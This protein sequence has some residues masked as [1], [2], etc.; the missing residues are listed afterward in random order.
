MTANLK[1]L[2]L[3]TAALIVAALIFL[4]P[5]TDWLFG[6]IAWI[7]DNRGI[8]WSVFIV[9]Y[10][11]AT[12]LI[13]PGSILTLGAGFVFGLPVGL[14]LVSVGSVLGA[15]AAF[16]VGRF[17]AREWVERKITDI[18]RFRAIDRAVN[19]D[20]FMI[21]FLIRLSPIFPF[22]LTNY[23]L[24]LTGIR[25]RDYF[26]ASWIGMLPGTVLYVYIGTLAQSVAELASGDLDT[27]MAGRVLLAGGFIATLILT[28]VIT[29]RATRMLNQRLGSEASSGR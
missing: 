24:G 5:V 29:R 6:G 21:V 25:F 7:Q 8:A 10:I 27:G 2:L 13:I 9:S 11:M 20:G 26:F 16:L 18:P 14:V 19:V 15:A 28:I 1:P 22:N 3:A 4:L 17:F 12:V 23:G